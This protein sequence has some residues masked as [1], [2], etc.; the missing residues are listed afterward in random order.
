MK[1][2][3]MR[4]GSIESAPHQHP[5]GL[6]RLQNA[7]KG[8]PLTDGMTAFNISNFVN[9]RFPTLVADPTEGSRRG[10]SKEPLTF[11]EILELSLHRIA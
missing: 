9:F 7:V 3:S 5:V 6:Q 4:A 11:L 8:L 2:V 10:S 1:F